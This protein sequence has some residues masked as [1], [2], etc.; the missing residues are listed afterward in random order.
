MIRVFKT[1]TFARWSRKTGLTDDAL[2]Q[3][4]AEMTQGLVDA[5]LGGHVLKK[6]VA[7][8]GLGKR[9]GARTIVATRMTD[10]WFY[11]YGFGKNE[12]DSINKNELKVLQEIAKELLSFDDRRLTAAMAAGEILEVSDGNDES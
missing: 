4:V 5:D 3:A 7:L 11:L 10:R 6:R 9:G 1:R 12:R 2:R 8:P